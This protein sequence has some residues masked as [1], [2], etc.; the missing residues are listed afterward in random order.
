MTTNPDLTTLLAAVEQALAS[1]STEQTSI[2][3]QI[4]VAALRAARESGYAVALVSREAVEA[5]RAW[6][7]DSCAMNACEVARLI[8]MDLAGLLKETT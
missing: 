1:G 8:E 4:L 7:D 5:L 2:E 6:R 3:T